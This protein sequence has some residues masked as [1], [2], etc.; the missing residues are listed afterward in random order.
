[1]GV[2][3]TT[4][5]FL[6]DDD[7]KSDYRFDQ[8]AVL[9]TVGYRLSSGWNLRGAVGAIL[10]GSLEADDA[11]QR[12][13]DMNTGLVMSIAGS[14]QWTFGDAYFVNGSLSFAGAST[15]TREAMTTGDDI[16]LS[17][18]DLRLGA[19]AGRTFFD[20]WQPYLL[21]RL[22]AGPVLWQVDGQDLAGGDR[23]HFQFGVGSSLATSFGLLVT[24]DVSVLGERSASLGLG[25]NL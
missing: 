11:S 20:I 23:F 8:S 24:A 5:V 9:A 14:R 16:G 21:T 10:A 18:F 13:F 2:T 4:L 15:S 25:W 1:M 12:G 17:S 6:D 7:N 19:V 3:Q 22:F